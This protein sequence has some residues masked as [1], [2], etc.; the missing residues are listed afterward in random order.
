MQ[1][2]A[3]TFRGA[4]SAEGSMQQAHPLAPGAAGMPPGQNVPLRT[5]SKSAPWHWKSVAVRRGILTSGRRPC[6]SRFH[7]K[8]RGSTSGSPHSSAEG[9]DPARG[10][11]FHTLR[12]R[13]HMHD[14][15]PTHIPAR[16]VILVQDVEI[17]QCNRARH[18]LI[19]APTNYRI[20]GGVRGVMDSGT[21]LA[22]LLT[23][24]SP[25]D[26]RSWG[27]G[28]CGGKCGRA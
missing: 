9:R 16:V 19:V 20:M 6:S 13:A 14:K 11:G 12:M 8:T 22:A 28:W 21:G 26:K 18:R 15:W 3:G 2:E 27:Q 24:N 7:S 25:S 23:H 4:G 17:R 1:G 5:F 10:G